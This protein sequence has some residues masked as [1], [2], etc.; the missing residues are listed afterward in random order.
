MS[1]V[2]R[3]TVCA[4]YANTLNLVLV[5]M[6]QDRAAFAASVIQGQIARLQRGRCCQT[7]ARY[8]DWFKAS[9]RI[10]HVRSLVSGGSITELS[11]TDAQR[12]ALSVI[13]RIWGEALS[14][15]RASRLLWDIY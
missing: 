11:V 6:Q 1:R 13:L 7:D 10:G 4:L 3:S 2:I 8:A 5:G 15:P 14:K 12:D 9:S